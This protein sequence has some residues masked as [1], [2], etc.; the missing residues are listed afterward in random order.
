MIGAISSS[1][2]M[3]SPGAEEVSIQ[4]SLL[5]IGARVVGG[6]KGGEEERKNKGIISRSKSVLVSRAFSSLA[7]LQSLLPLLT[8]IVVSPSVH[9]SIWFGVVE[10]KSS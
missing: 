1:S 6:G 5:M 8:Y 2:K 3:I 9:V 4:G 10:L 7:L